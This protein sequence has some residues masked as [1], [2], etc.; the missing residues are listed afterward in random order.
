[1]SNEIIELA[2]MSTPTATTGIREGYSPENP[3]SGCPVEISSEIE[4]IALGA[5]LALRASKPGF[6]EY[7]D[8]ELFKIIDL[9]RKISG[10]K[11]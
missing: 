4:S 10:G 2:E 3:E 6:N 8:E 7:L 11:K 9:S 5:I 1:M